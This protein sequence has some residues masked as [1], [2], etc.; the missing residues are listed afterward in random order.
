M[1]IKVKQKASIGECYQENGALGQSENAA[2]LVEL[3]LERIQEP[4]QLHLF[5]MDHQ[6]DMSRVIWNLAYHQVIQPHIL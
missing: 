4:V 3:E 2:N 5:V 1:R 6:P